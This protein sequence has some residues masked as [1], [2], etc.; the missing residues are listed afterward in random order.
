MF[1]YLNNGQKN[2]W[3]SLFRDAIMTLSPT[4]LSK[5]YVTKLDA[6]VS[7]YNYDEAKSVVASYPVKFLNT[8]SIVKID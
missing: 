4:E 6:A 7:I 1:I 8:Q 5:Q 3:L 2:L